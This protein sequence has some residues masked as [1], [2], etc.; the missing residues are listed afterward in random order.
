MTTIAY[1]HKDKQIA[2]DSQ[3][4]MGG[5]ILSLN[6]EKWRE[7]EGCIFFTCGKSCDELMLIDYC[8]GDHEKHKGLIPEASC[9]MVDLDKTVWHCVVNNDSI[10]MKFELNCSL[11]IGSGEK[12]A[13]AAMDFKMT[14]KEAVQYAVTRDCYT[15]GKIHLYDVNSGSFI[16]AN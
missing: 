8:M 5:M 7:S 4:S 1:N 3:S 10:L 2:V 15:G 12:F 11:S 13:I 16:D 9:F 6:E 14:A